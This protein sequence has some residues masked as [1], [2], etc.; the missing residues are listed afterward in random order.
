[1]KN[2]LLRQYAEDKK[3]RIKHN[4]LTEQFKDNKEILKKI[5]DV[6]NY[7]D[8]T[9]GRYV[10]TLENK[11]SKL[12]KT[13]Y[14][15]GVGSGTDAIFLSLK[16]L[17]IKEGDEVITPTYSFY[18]TSGAIATAGAKPI[19][20]DI[21]ND[22][23]IDVNLIEKSITKKT[24]AI[25]PVHWSGRICNMKK[26]K[27]I[28]KK[29]SLHIVEDACHAILA[30]DSNKKFA[31]TFGDAG[32]FSFHPLKNLNVWGDG[33][34]ITTNNYTLYKKLKLLRN[35]G[36]EGRNN[37]LIYGYNSRLDTIQAVVALEMLKKINMITN[38]RIKNAR[39]LNKN[40]S[41]IKNINII[42]E[43]KDFKTVFHLYQFFAKDRNALN[44][45][46]RDN[47]I[48]SKVHYPIPLHLHK[49]AKIYDY[50]KGQFPNAEFLSSHVLSLPIHEF[51][52]KKELDFI[53]KK[54][55][56]FYN[57]N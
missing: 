44:R 16:A 54:I 49:S 43:P 20:V 41:K 29:Y 31:G 15:I 28:A 5:L 7:N 8:F 30:Q 22:L 18:A 23:N 6:V 9:L 55:R 10:D 57:E 40:L 14:A 53:I 33:G 39:Y 47:G 51:V 3:L 2:F 52:T 38:S 46:L 21:S 45:Y 56:E 12:I 13:K 11:F 42:I 35:H 24:K 19:F 34:I 1:M 50:K 17:G 27:Q 32:C 4:Y 37:C 25:V 26:I 48:D 36:L